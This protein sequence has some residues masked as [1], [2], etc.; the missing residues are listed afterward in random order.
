MGKHE[1][2][3][4]WQDRKKRWRER[5]EEGGTIMEGTYRLDKQGKRKKGAWL[6]FWNL[7]QTPPHNPPFSL[8]VSSAVSVL[9]ALSLSPYSP[10][11]WII[12]HF[13]HCLLCKSEGELLVDGFLQLKSSY[14]APLFISLSSSSFF[15]FS[16]LK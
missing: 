16:F 7:T 10:V 8:S 2:I 11:L 9:H 4:R 3:K 14:E 13:S 1:K 6:E 12:S 5:E 15:N